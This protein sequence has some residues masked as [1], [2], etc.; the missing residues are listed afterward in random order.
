M[1]RGSR[2]YY[3]RAQGSYLND[4]NNI[5]P[6]AARKEWEGMHPTA[7]KFSKTDLAKFEHTWAGLP[8]LVCLGAEKNF[9]KF[10]DAQEADGEPPVDEMYFRRLIAKA[11][12]FREAEKLVSA[13]GLVG[14]RANTVAYTL[15]WLIEKSG[16]RIHLDRIWKDQRLPKG[17]CEAISVVCRAA[18]SHVLLV[19][20]TLGRGNANEGTKKPECWEVLRNLPI[21]VPPAWESEWAAEPFQIT[22][23]D[24][25]AQAAEWDRLR[26]NFLSDFRTFGELEVQTGKS[27]FRNRNH[28]PVSVYA[29]MTWEQLCGR[30]G[31]AAG[32]RRKLM[33]IMAATLSLN[34]VAAG[35][36][37]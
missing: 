32:K 19:G 22:R 6:P 25:T 30:P 26:N 14:Y 4:K 27:W 7:Q 34:P 18:H 3:E 31:F 24:I 36:H 8:H 17:L 9:L 12:L 11:K 20:P 16:R 37:A 33:E 10:A 15:A 2:W 5:H 23:V 29:V 35:V 28:E 13:Q 1:E 21:E